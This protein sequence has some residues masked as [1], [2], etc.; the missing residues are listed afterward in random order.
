[1]T[2]SFYEFLQNDYAKNI[3]INFYNEDDVHFE[4]EEHMLNMEVS[5]NIKINKLDLRHEKN[6]DVIYT[7]SKKKRE[8]EKL[9]KRS[10][11]S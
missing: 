6:T 7:K 9:L 2:N 4:I 11:E 10:L 5:E 8:I 1:M 3:Y